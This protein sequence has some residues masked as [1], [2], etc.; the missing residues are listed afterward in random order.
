MIIIITP[1]HKKITIHVVCVINVETDLLKT[2]VLLKEKLVVIEDLCFIMENVL[3]IILR[4]I[5]ETFISAVKMEIV[6]FM[7][8]IANYA[9]LVVV[10]MIRIKE[11]LEWM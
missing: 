10:V 9:L 6:K 1:K 5:I 4:M 7:K 2:V 11:D 8:V 3:M